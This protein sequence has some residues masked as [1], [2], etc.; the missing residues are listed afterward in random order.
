LPHPVVTDL[1]TKPATQSP[2]VGPAYPVVAHFEE[3]ISARVIFS[4]A[5]IQPTSAG[6]RRIIRDYADAKT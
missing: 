3:S 5:R 6:A 4:E 1:R 2:N